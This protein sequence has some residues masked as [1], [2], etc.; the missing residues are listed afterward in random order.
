MNQSY[1]AIADLVARV[2]R[3][4]RALSL[5]RTALISLAVIMGSVVAAA[6]LL[7]ATQGALRLVVRAIF[8]AACFG[9][10][11]VAAVLAWLARE[12][13]TT[14]ALV[15]EEV[16]PGLNNALIN[17]LQLHHAAED[18]GP[19]G[20]FSRELLAKHLRDTAALLPGLDLKKAAP[21]S[22]LKKP[23]QAALIFALLLALVL[24]AWPGRMS[25]GL[26]AMFKE[27]WRL[28]RV[29]GQTAALPL[30][31]G[32]FNLSYSFPVYTEIPDQKVTHTNGDL[33]ALKGTSIRIETRVLEPLKSASLVTSTG[34]RLAMAV[35]D[36]T[37]LKVELILSAAGSYYI[38]GID[39]SG[40]PRAETRSHR[41]VVD[42]DLAPKIDMLAP[43][44]DMQVAAEGSLP[45]SFSAGDDFGVREIALVY[46][47]KNAD[48]RI[49]IRNIVENGEKEVEDH[50]E[51]QLSDLKFEPG[52]KIPFHL[53]AVD[54]DEVSGGNVGQSETRVLE[55]FSARKN[56]QAIL[57]QEDE[58][59]NLMIDHLSSSL[60]AWLK[61]KDGKTNP[62]ETEPMLVTEGMAIVS[63][64]QAVEIE[65]LND[66]L[67]EPMVTEAISEMSDRYS[68]R[69]A[70]RQKIAGN[71]KTLSAEDRK[72]LMDFR[73]SYRSG[74]ELDVLFL[75]KLMK[76][77]RMADLMSQADELKQA[78]GKL[79]ELMA[80]YQKTGDPAL[81]DQIERAM[82]DLQS[83]WESLMKRMAEMRKSLP[84]EFLN[85]DAFADSNAMDLN[86]QMEKL[87]Q[88]L[89]DGDLK[90]AQAL[91]DQL[92]GNMNQWM[93]SLEKSAQKTGETMSKEMMEKM[94]GLSDKLGELIERQKQVEDQVQKISN[95]TLDR[96]KLEKLPKPTQDELTKLIAAFQEASV[97]AGQAMYSMQSTS[98]EKKTKDL[99][100][101]V[102]EQKSALARLF[103]D[104]R[105]DASGILAA[106]EDGDVAAALAKTVEIQ[107]RLGPAIDA[108]RAFQ[109]A[110]PMGPKSTL[111]RFDAHAMIALDTI[112]KILDLLSKLKQSNQSSLTPEEQMALQ[113]LSGEQDQIGAE[114]QDA[115]E[116]YEE[117]RAEAPSLPGSISQHL[118][119]A[120][121]SSADASGEMRLGDP[122]RALTPSRD[123][124][125]HLEQAQGKLNQ[126]QQQMGQGMM[127][128]GSGS[129][130]GSGGG[131]GGRGNREGQGGFSTGKVEIPGA[132]RHKGPEEF[133]KEVMKA[134]Q[135]ASPESYRNLNRDYYQRLVR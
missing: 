61:D 107:G 12:D 26:A 96:T 75:D 17:S 106:V 114:I 46:S 14:A 4:R 82:S 13:L 42:E 98:P 21:G 15:I 131:S 34:S 50:Y 10:V 84:E 20:A 25:Q 7:P 79:A 35:K 100:K 85:A 111:D 68:V 1:Q 56:H 59:L 40:R 101:A 54:N 19:A 52:E 77:Q 58:L 116:Q 28:N 87:R 135:E 122:A 126:S 127:G 66:E 73:E 6:L 89:N 115:L 11:V 8:L 133:R 45:I 43:V 49:V 71:S 120:K 92:F 128:G 95:Q 91:A 29:Q 27:P 83:A 48:Q 78:R 113:Q 76:R 125:M 134:M 22:R 93:N 74:L 37:E 86:D 88:A 32:D 18:P 117:M 81:L 57:A 72:K 109:G 99:L 102:A 64:L 24:I 119:Q 63:M 67:A 36:G 103:L 80:Q 90:A 51:W 47:R 23:G 123:T 118:S 53:E 110:N 69:L 30:T 121:T 3:K 70:E 16:N 38:E 33:A 65:L 105:N 129:G 31:T 44:A 60:E 132:D 94:S 97:G 5:L 62:L 9:P 104:L 108:V 41:M 112:K 2:R 55:I 124:R 39:K 130:S